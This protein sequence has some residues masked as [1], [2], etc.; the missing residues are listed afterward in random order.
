MKAIGMKHFTIDELTRSA[1]AA[2][3]G[4]DNTPTAAARVWLTRLV[5]QVLDP[6]REL[7]GHPLRVT[8]GYRCQALNRAVGGAR[9][10]QHM[11][12][13]AADI[14][15]GSRGENRRL[16]AILRA[17]GLPFDQV[18]DERD[19]SWVHVSVAERPRRMLLK[20]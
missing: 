20:L 10:S 15:T 17:S 14:T 9:H 12:G 16:I 19:G 8:S 6:L 18:I 4:I 11:R 2:A 7:W 3:L 13:Q 1:T 5:A